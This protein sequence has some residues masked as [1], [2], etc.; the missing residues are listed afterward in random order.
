M[1]TRM[2]RAAWQTLAITAL[3]VFVVSLDSTVLY[4]AFPSIRSSYEHVSPEALS[5]ILNVY[6]IGYGGF[7]S[8][9]AQRGSD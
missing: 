1:R 6:T 5:W 3:A 4:V 8:Q 9:V 2:L 7:D